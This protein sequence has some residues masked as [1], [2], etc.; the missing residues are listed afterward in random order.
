MKLKAARFGLLSSLD[1][2]LYYYFNK[3]IF[4][5][6]WHSVSLVGTFFW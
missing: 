6:L 5:F 4:H 2:L 1:P 3:S